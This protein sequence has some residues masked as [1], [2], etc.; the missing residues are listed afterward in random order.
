MVD[1]NGK[2]NPCSPLEW[3]E[4]LVSVVHVDLIKWR[5]VKNVTRRVAEDTNAAGIRLDCNY[6]RVHVEHA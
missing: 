6:K 5:V 1:V 2:K 3:G 4:S